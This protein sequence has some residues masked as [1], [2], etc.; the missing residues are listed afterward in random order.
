MFKSTGWQY[1]QLLRAI[2]GRVGAGVTA[3]AGPSEEGAVPFKI[4]SCA[5]TLI[6]KFEPDAIPTYCF[7]KYL[8]SD[9]QLRTTEPWHYPR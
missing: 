2:A 9:R 5:I 6:K 3:A 1:R 8:T 4:I 7:C